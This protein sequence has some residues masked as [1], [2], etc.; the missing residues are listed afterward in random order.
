MKED[1]QEEEEGGKWDAAKAK[2]GEWKNAAKDMF[3][4]KEDDKAMEGKKAN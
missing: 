2:G 1:N 3:K 4:G